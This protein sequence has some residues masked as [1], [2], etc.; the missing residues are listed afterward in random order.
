MGDSFSDSKNK[1]GGNNWNPYTSKWKAALEKG[2][3]VRLNG[4]ENI[5]YLGTSSGT[6][7]KHISKK[8]SGI[9]FGVE[10]SFQMAIPFVR[11]SEKSDNVAPLFCDANDVEYIK[12][13]LY[14]EKINILFQD[15]PAVGQVRILKR[16]SKLVGKE[17][18]IFLSLKTQSISQD[19][20]KETEKKVSK[21]LEK[22][23][24]IKDVQSMEPF[25]KKHCFFILEK[26]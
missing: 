1:F 18:R 23:F 20:W 6:T 17:C 4:D 3:D 12:N 21:N 5:L 15:I 7:I 11:L 10:K 13:H 24:V 8:T 19:G 26:R 25:H 2:M 9:I 16:I 14:G 22:Y